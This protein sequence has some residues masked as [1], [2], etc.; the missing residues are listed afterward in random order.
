[1]LRCF[2]I[3]PLGK[4]TVNEEKVVDFDSI[5][6]KLIQP[7]LE[8]ADISGETTED[9]FKK[10]AISADLFRSIV[11]ADVIVCDVTLHNANVFYKLGIRHALRRTATVLIRGEPVATR[12]PFNIHGMRHLNYQIDSP[13]DAIAP[14]QAMIET[15]RLDQTAADSPVFLT[16][17]D[18]R[19]PNL[20][21]PQ[22]LPA[23]LRRDI[24]QA[25]DFK[26]A[27]WLRAL[28]REIEGLPSQWQAL[29]RIGRAQRN[30]GDFEGAR[31]TLEKVAST[32]IGRVAANITLSEVYDRLH[33]RTRRRDGGGGFQQSAWDAAQ[34][35]HKYAAQE[36]ADVQTDARA[37]YC[38]NMRSRWIA[39][40]EH[41]PSEE[42][43]RRAAVDPQLLEAYHGYRTAF[44]ADTSRFQLGMA[45]AQLGAILL[46]L[47]R[48]AQW[49]DLFAPRDEDNQEAVANGHERGITQQT[50][51]LIDVAGHN[52]KFA[53]ARQDLADEQKRWARLAVADWAF[54]KHKPGAPEDR[55]IRRYTEGVAKFG[56]AFLQ[57]AIGQLRMFERLGVKRELAANILAAL[58]P[59]AQAAP[60]EVVNHVVV[61]AGHCVDADQRV[62]PRFPASAVDQAKELIRNELRRLQ[63][64]TDG[65]MAVFA[66]A[67]PGADLLCHEA[68]R[69]LGIRST[70]CLPMPAA[71]FRRKVLSRAP[72]SADWM[73]RFGAL[74][75]RKIGT[76]ELSGA[77]GLPAW[78]RKDT[79]DDHLIRS[80]RLVFEIATTEF[81]LA[82]H[83]SENARLSVILLWDGVPYE[84]RPGG[85]AHMMKL[86]QEHESAKMVVI[87]T[88]DL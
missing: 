74:R 7:A 8:R 52:A 14:L 77:D 1:M 83:Y 21:S 26:I 16:L 36:S 2:I 46:D 6:A 11:N 25:E 60:P 10:G 69:E 78:W 3:R 56:G 72:N 18:L 47:A 9:I 85:A 80:N 42:E 34:A 31:R 76:I 65:R 13:E 58:E 32:E 39:L 43:R 40:F 19:P 33:K 86:A 59:R 71:T 75:Q 54:L 57:T 15:S 27:G 51:R 49:V 70:M 45:A 73:R 35:A 37:A 48:D 38:K 5:E 88:Q 4:N 28:S 64:E 87:K 44:H 55:V 12:P 81:E 82:Q 67:A 50:R 41:L 22:L 17:K 66:S 24:E 23:S 61:L 79:N 20:S 53:A 63:R 29:I 68:C 62:Q 84:E 30:I